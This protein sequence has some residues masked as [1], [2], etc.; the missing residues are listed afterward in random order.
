MLIRLIYASTATEGVE[1]NEFK[2]I[3]ATAQSKN[4]SHD[5]T[6]MLAFNS[7]VFLQ[8]LEG[9]RDK[10]NQ[11]YTNLMHDKRHTRVSVLAFQEIEERLWA[12]WAMGYAAPSSD[13][14]ALFLKYSVHG[15]FNPYALTAKAAEKMLLELTN[16]SIAMPTMSPDTQA[17]APAQAD[18]SVFARMLGR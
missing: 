7:K 3:L 5:L 9:D 14:R 10:V 12:S 13:N 6:G 17:A 2:R 15:T 16:K 18:K 11:L 4:V 1:I 8:A